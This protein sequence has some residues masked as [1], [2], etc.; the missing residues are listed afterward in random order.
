MKCNQASTRVPVTVVC[1]VRIAYRC[2][3]YIPL[4]AIRRE[5]ALLGFRS[6]LYSP[7][8]F[9]CNAPAGSAIIDCR[10]KSI[11]KC[12]MQ[13]L[14]SRTE[15][16]K[17][18][19]RRMLNGPLRHKPTRNGHNETLLHGHLRLRTPKYNHCYAQKKLPFELSI[20]VV[21]NEPD[22]MAFRYLL[23]FNQKTFAAMLVI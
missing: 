13:A 7:W 2:T 20:V 19:R 12:M 9:A 8:I 18:R 22:S 17:P 21:E 3:I 10:P 15:G 11:A 5:F 14:S 4:K 1:V 23:P 16:K 6:T